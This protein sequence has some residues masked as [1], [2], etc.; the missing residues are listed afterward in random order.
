[1]T[2]IW[3]YCHFVIGDLIM[4]MIRYITKSQ[5]SS[6]LINLMSDKKISSLQFI[7]F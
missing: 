1:M 6:Y 5:K 2:E 4:G 7:Q 3:D